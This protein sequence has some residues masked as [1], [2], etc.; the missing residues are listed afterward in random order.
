MDDLSEVMAAGGDRVKI[1]LGQSRSLRT[2]LVM[3]DNNSSPDSIRIGKRSKPAA[4]NNGSSQESSATITT[5][6][7][8][9]ASSAYH[10]SSS[11]SPFK[12]GSFSPSDSPPPDT[13]IKSFGYGSGL[14]PIRQPA[15]SPVHYHASTAAA[16]MSGKTLGS[17]GGSLF[18]SSKP[19]RNDA[20]STIAS[21]SDVLGSRPLRDRTNHVLRK[22][23][24]HLAGHLTKELDQRRPSLPHHALGATTTTKT[25]GGHRRAGSNDSTTSTAVAA[26]LLSRSRGLKSGLSQHS[27]LDAA[28]LTSTSSSS[29]FSRRSDRYQHNHHQDTST[30]ATASQHAANSS[31]S[32]SGCSS[33]LPKS[34]S[35]SSRSSFESTGSLLTP[36][37][38]AAIMAD[39]MPSQ[40]AFKAAEEG[41]VVNK[42]QKRRASNAALTV[43]QS[44]MLA[45]AIHAPQVSSLITST[46]GALPASASTSLA[47]ATKQP[48]PSV[49]KAIRPAILKRASSCGAAEAAAATQPG[50][51]PHADWQAAFMMSR[52][53]SK[54]VGSLV[55]PDTPVKRS[56][57]GHAKAHSHGSHPHPK[58]SIP[59]EPVPVLHRDVSSSSSTPSVTAT[60]S[61]DLLLGDAPPSS[62]SGFENSSSSPVDSMQASPT[63]RMSDAKR[64]TESVRKGLLRRLS[65]GGGQSDPSDQE[66]TPTKAGSAQRMLGAT[67][68]PSPRSHSSVEANSQRGHEL[69]TVTTPVKQQQYHLLHSHNLPSASPL[70]APRH[71]LPH[72][73]L[74]SSNNPPRTSL[75]SGLHHH[76]QSAPLAIQMEEEE[77]VF[78]SRFVVLETL[79]K[80]AFSQVFKVKERD[81]EGVYAVKRA[82]GMF[83]GNKD[84]L[85]HLEE[86]DI[87]RHLSRPAHPNVITFIDAWEQS[88]QLFIQTELCLGSLAFFLEEY[89][90]VVERLDEARAWK[91]ARELADGLY[92]IHS[93]G[94]IHF[95]I[96]PANVLITDKGSLKIGD[97]GM[98]TRWPRVDAASIIR[99]SGMGGEAGSTGIR[100]ITDREGDR[101]Y[102]APEMLDGRYT[103]AADIF[104]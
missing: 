84:R 62:S 5:P 21:S 65:S 78:D 95:D 22:S 61:L 45:A 104:R 7:R 12:F 37:E 101:D 90:S 34:L 97:F 26:G 28:T 76:R 69:R 39:V 71:S 64:T 63:V 100:P 53:L 40:A 11:S 47:T 15:F 14:G 9:F 67:P 93:M 58:L 43:G 77:D 49:M 35:T 98:A 57:L 20:S 83:E 3:D 79:G 51:S 66:G 41:Q 54:A 27:D 50:L 36:E 24:P 91:I 73:A 19:L 30:D 68:T 32:S 44:P 75:T 80:G 48:P 94:V 52:P 16:A 103:M 99:G 6:G 74:S 33:L 92:H 81:G 88:R 60:T 55:M 96:K 72:F 13:P 38:E 87:L 70:V 86:V 10:A 31:I 82:K 46:N 25:D 8:P 2:G 89:G 1:P 23:A 18:S 59:I 4:M 17:G 56:S 29:A 42:F 102:M 85:R